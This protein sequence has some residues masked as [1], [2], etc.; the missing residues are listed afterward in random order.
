MH[1]QADVEELS[2]ETPE[3]DELEDSSWGTRN[4]EKKHGK[5]S[6]M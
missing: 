1:S 6:R 5:Y 2:S 4:S 3:I